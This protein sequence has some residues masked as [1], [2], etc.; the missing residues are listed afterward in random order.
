MDVAP[1]RSGFF[2]MG[3][4]QRPLAFYIGCAVFL[5]LAAI[6]ITSLLF[7]GGQPREDTTENPGDAAP[8]PQSTYTP[9]IASLSDVPSSEQIETFTLGEASAVSAPE[10][11]EGAAVAVE[12]ASPEGGAGGDP[13]IAVALSD[14]SKSA[15]ENALAPYKTDNIPV[16]FVFMDLDT[17]A[18]IAYNADTRVYGASSIKGPYCTYVCQDIID[19]GSKELTDSC[20]AYTDSFKRKDSTSIK[21]L[22]KDTVVNSSNGSYAGLREGLG[23]NNYE[24]WLGDKDVSYNIHK[25]DDWFAWYSARDAA[26][27]WMNT[28]LYLSETDSDASRYLKD[29][30]SNTNRSFI[31]DGIIGET[32]E[33]EV[34][35][36]PDRSDNALTPAQLVVSTSNNLMD[37]KAEYDRID[38][39]TIL[40]KAGWCTTDNNNKTTYDSV[41]DNGIITI[42]G[43][44][45]ILCLMSGARD[46]QANERNLANLASA[47]FSA[48]EALQV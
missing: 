48:R 23:G 15:I 5:L 33:E 30:M 28:Y 25:D 42:D 21:A 26:K 37:Y 8:A 39:I 32:T 31:R 11:A 2:S 10:S 24:E 6:L 34:S 46:T 22:I 13:Q 40:N 41:C 19:N 17:G 7:P 43:N 3:F 14:E 47:V 1:R 20:R 29:Q 44:N 4:A 16:G 36:V 18:G 27:L 35:L 38:N 45:Y 9:T 12:G